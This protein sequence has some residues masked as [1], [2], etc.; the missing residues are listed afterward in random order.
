MRGWV[1]ALVVQARVAE[2]A[3]AGAPGAGGAGGAVYESSAVLAMPLAQA[4][5]GGRGGRGRA[6]GGTVND[7]A[8]VT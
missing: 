7:V 8:V 2:A 3:E 6:V 1:S 5:A 4:R